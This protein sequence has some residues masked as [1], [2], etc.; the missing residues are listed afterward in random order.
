MG[1][2]VHTYVPGD[3]EVGPDIPEDVAR[4]AIKRGDAKRLPKK[5]QRETKVA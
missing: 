1:D 5:G 2:A 3:Y 4:D